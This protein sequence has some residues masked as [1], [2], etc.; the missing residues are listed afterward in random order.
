MRFLIAFRGI[1]NH[2]RLQELRSV[3]SS[4]RRCENDELGTLDLVAAYDELT[5][6]P[7]PVDDPIH[8]RNT[9]RGAAG[10]VLYGEVFAY[11][12]LRDEEEAAALAARCVLVRAILV[13]IGHGHD[14]ASC[15]SSITEEQVQIAC[16][17]LLSSDAPSYRVVI[18]AFGRSLQP[19]AQLERVHAFSFV[20]ARFAGP[21]RMQ[22]AQQQL[23]VLE[24]A[25]PPRGHGYRVAHPPPR[26]VLFARLVARGDAGV[27][28]AYS[29]KQRIYLGPTSMD[30]ELSFVMCN[31]GR[32]R[33]GSLVLDPFAGT[34]SVLIACAARGAYTVA[35]DISLS[36]LRG[37]NGRGLRANFAQY[38]LCMPL[39]VVRCDALHSAFRSNVRVFDALV[40]DPPYG[41]KEGAKMF[42]EEA[43]DARL[44]DSHYQG[45]QRVRFD[46]LLYA[47]LD[48]AVDTLVDDGRLVYWLPTTPEYTH[49]DLPTH[50]ML[51][52]VHNCEQPLTSRMSRRLIVMRRREGDSTNGSRRRERG[53]DERRPAHFDLA[54]KLLH[55]PE[56]DES[57]LKIHGFTD[58]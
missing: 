46:D 49:E 43:V 13:P 16:A 55:Q 14:V 30:A 34:G 3:L 5:G 8:V 28:A 31:M 21:V 39:G 42:R 9:K 35:A 37:R 23:W 47:L 54:R 19:A 50:P 1:H 36:A 56:R 51:E 12:S 22:N 18:E 2:F 48:F 58:R 41:I 53:T 38:E 26:Q 15:A 6:A 29:L 45:T 44:R 7:S 32:V 25:F 33:Y 17:S 4:L 40:T 27:G 11:A 24:D 20:H 57:R 52:L 10:V